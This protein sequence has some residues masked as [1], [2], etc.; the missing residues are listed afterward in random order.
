MS[1]IFPYEP[2]R[3]AIELFF[4]TCSAPLLGSTGEGACGK[5]ACGE[6]RTDRVVILNRSKNEAGKGIA[7]HCS[8]SP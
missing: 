5:I 4:N 7:E 8:G 1:L 2:L 3:S 6:K